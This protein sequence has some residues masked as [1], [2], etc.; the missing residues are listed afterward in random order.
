MFP[1]NVKVKILISPTWLCC[2]ACIV[3]C[4]GNMTT[5]C[6]TGDTLSVLFYRISM[7]SYAGMM[8]IKFKWPILGKTVSAFCIQAGLPCCTFYAECGIFHTMT[9]YSK[10]AFVGHP[11][12]KHFNISNNFVFFMSSEDLTTNTVNSDL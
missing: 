8:D 12:Y 10:I 1:K 6:V 11:G 7:K 3:S 2:L 4:V 5:I 9:S